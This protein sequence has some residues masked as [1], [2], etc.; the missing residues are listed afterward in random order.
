MVY[1]KDSPPLPS[2]HASFSLSLPQQGD[3]SRLRLPG[4]ITRGWGH[5][6]LAEPDWVPSEA[7]VCTAEEKVV[8]GKR[9]H[10]SVSFF[11][12]FKMPQVA[13]FLEVA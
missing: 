2:P 4:A 8:E 6:T 11:F 10:F 12:F 1:H 9:R 7:A 13:L 5:E 3:K